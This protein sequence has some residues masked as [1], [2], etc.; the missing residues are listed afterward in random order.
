MNGEHLFRRN[1]PR[2]SFPMIDRR[3]LLQ[4]T[5]AL[6]MLTAAAVPKVQA[7]ALPGS[8]ELSG[9]DITLHIGATTIRIDGRPARAVAINGGVP[10]PTLRLREGK[11]CA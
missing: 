4:G 2:M 3:H 6:A 5:A 9:E 8:R 7:A 10:G 11:S 1:D